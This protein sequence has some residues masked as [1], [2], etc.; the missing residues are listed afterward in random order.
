MRRWL[1]RREEAM[2]CRDFGE[3][4]LRVPSSEITPGPEFTST[5]HKRGSLLGRYSLALAGHKARRWLNPWFIGFWKLRLERFGCGASPCRAVQRWDRV[6]RDPYGI[7]VSR[8]VRAQEDADPGFQR[9]VC[10]SP[11]MEG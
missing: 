7:G 5:E 6:S 3:M 8:W 9:P 10:M 1:L 4:L 2:C 11:P